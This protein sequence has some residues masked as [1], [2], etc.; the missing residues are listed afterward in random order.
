MVVAFATLGTLSYQVW[1]LFH[2]PYKVP[3]VRAAAPS[4]DVADWAAEV[5]RQEKHD[6]MVFTSGLEVGL[7]ALSASS[8]F[9]YRRLDRHLKDSHLARNPK[10]ERPRRSRAE[11]PP[12]ASGGN[13]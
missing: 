13:A 8:W 10:V 5:Y 3:A 4:L 12:P 1:K 9:V 2:N 11:T 7:I 6:H